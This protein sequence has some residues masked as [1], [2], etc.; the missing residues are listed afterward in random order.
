M[1][2]REPTGS[3]PVL[4]P[5]AGGRC[6]SGLSQLALGMAASSAASQERSKAAQPGRDT[7]TEYG[8]ASQQLRGCVALAAT[9]APLGPLCTYALW[10][11]GVGR[12]RPRGRAH[13]SAASASLSARAQAACGVP[14]CSISTL[15]AKNSAAWPLSSTCFAGALMP[16]R[17]APALTSDLPGYARLLNGRPRRA[18]FCSFASS[19]GCDGGCFLP[20]LQRPA[21]ATR[22]WLVQACGSYSVAPALAVRAQ[23]GA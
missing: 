5:V 10:R 3:W 11:R 19:T 16:G 2:G 18:C 23:T 21:R 4:P 9:S 15:F 17:A 1:L 8:N 6:A 12:G 22:S 13:R 7:A 14:R 20:L